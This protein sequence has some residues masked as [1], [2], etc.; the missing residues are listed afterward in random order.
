MEERR[1]RADIIEVFKIVNGLS[2]LPVLTFFEFQA[3]TRTREHSLK[4]I[5]KRKQKDLR[6]QFFSKRVVNRWNKL[7]ASA[8]EATMVNSFKARLQKVQTKEIGIFMD[9]ASV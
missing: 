2:I 1:N 3:D 5:K 6:L 4:L 9:T 8:L 7:P